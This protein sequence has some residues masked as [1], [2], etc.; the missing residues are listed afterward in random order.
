MIWSRIGWRKIC[1]KSGMHG[2]DMSAMEHRLL[3]VA[4]DLFYLFLLVFLPFSIFSLDIGGRNVTDKV[5]FYLS[6]DD[7]TCYVLTS[8]VKIQETLSAFSY[9]ISFFFYSA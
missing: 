7:L 3:V 1:F 8:Q 9:I 2:D 4:N 5:N 6:V